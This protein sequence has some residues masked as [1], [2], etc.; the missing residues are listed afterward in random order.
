[1]QTAVISCEWLHTSLYSNHCQM[2]PKQY[3]SI[4]YSEDLAVLRKN[5]DLSSFGVTQAPLLLVHSNCPAQDSPMGPWTGLGSSGFDYRLCVPGSRSADMDAD[6]S[7]IIIVQISTYAMSARLPDLPYLPHLHIWPICR[8]CTSTPC[9]SSPHLHVCHSC[10][11]T[12][13]VV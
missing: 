6:S 7:K 11:F 8:M 9:P 5:D 13:K 12:A 4:Q 1:M 3:P 10:G 2:N